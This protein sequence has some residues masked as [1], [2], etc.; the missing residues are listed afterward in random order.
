M[1]TNFSRFGAIIGLG[2]LVWACGS[3]KKTTDGDDDDG[4]RT[5]D[6]TDDSGTTKTP[7]CVPGT[8][9]CEGSVVKLCDAQG[10]QESVQQTCPSSQTCSAGACV[11]R[12]CV[13]NSRFC[14]EGAIRKCNSDGAAST[15]VERC[16]GGLFCRAEDDDVSC[17]PQACSVGDALCEG[18]VATTCLNDGSGP[19]PG[20][21]DCSTTQQLCYKGQCHDI[22]CVAGSK[23]CQHDDVYLCGDN[24][25]DLKLWADCQPSEVCDADLG[26][27]RSKVCEPGK[28][29]CDSTRV[30]TCNGFGSGWLPD[31]KDC[32]AE[33]KICTSGTCKKRVCSPNTSYCQDG[34]LYSCDNTG[35]VSSQVECG[36]NAHCMSSGA[37]AYC[38]TDACI[39]G[40][41][42]CRDDVIVTCNDDGTLPA[43]GGTACGEGQK[44]DAGVCVTR[45]EQNTSFC[46]G[47]DVFYCQWDG[48]S[49]VSQYC[50]G[51]NKCEAAGGG[52]ARCAPFDCSPSTTACLGNQ[53]GTCA[54]GGESLSAVS[55]D[56]TA[57]AEVCTSAST[58]AATTTDTIGVAE[59]S[60]ELVSAGSVIG[61]AIKVNS[62]RKLTEMQMKL[63]LDEPV[64]LRWLVYEETG[65][66]YVAK[67]D[68]VDA[69]VSGDGFIS[70]GPFEANL[71][72]GKRYLFAVAIAGGDGFVY[73]DKAP[74]PAS[75]SFGT[76]LGR[77]S[78]AYYATISDFLYSDVVA[79]MKLTTTAP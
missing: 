78:S 13:P 62:A 79:Q 42:A 34:E 18:N 36:A 14:N 27:C 12:A 43:T 76:T 53:I 52:S 55:K 31:L 8:R 64:S 29:Q 4:D 69:N 48:T 17:S 60:A 73:N 51:E 15:V 19:K 70:S 40:Q 39:A 72:A 54:D 23:L 45:C 41:P 9:R 67:V 2:L 21:T 6:Q 26:T 65:T 33:D 77:M 32:A 16:T 56:C 37:Y 1:G 74:F 3:S 75:A 50:E 24:G 22:A 35:T 61:D 30:V 57:T 58:C 25:T 7:I 5:N 59:N 11:D 20:G 46:K 71:K 68:H 63:K 49:A 28:V 10:L 47:N 38:T 66:S 44:C